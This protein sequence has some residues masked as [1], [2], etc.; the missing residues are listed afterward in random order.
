MSFVFLQG[1]QKENSSSCMLKGKRKTFWRQR[2][3]S[4]ESIT[5]SFRN[6]LPSL[7]PG[8]TVELNFNI[9]SFQSVKN[10]KVVYRYLQ[11]LLGKTADN[12]QVEQYQKHFPEH[13]LLRE[14][15]KGTVYFKYSEWVISF[16]FIWIVYTVFEYILTDHFIRNS[17]TFM[18]LSNHLI[19]WQQHNA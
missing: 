6:A 4:G 15:K 14:E 12:L 7:N 3:R 9:H 2:Y 10:P 13:Q 8:L 19:V 18:Q 11:S 5:N 1:V 17:C 16:S